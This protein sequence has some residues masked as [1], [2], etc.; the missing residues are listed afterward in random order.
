LHDIA[1]IEQSQ[2]FE[3]ALIYV[4]E[5]EDIDL[6]ILSVSSFPRRYSKAAYLYD[7]RKINEHVLISISLDSTSNIQ[8]NR[9]HTFD[10]TTLDEA[11][12]CQL[13]DIKARIPECGWHPESISDL[14]DIPVP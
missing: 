4:S 6:L 13:E 2:M 9:R 10:S 7:I 5:S 3:Q 11:S 12:N 14:S 1:E 8:S